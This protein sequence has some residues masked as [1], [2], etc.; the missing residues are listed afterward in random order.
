MGPAQGLGLGPQVWGLGAGAWGLGAWGLGPG[1]YLA[2]WGLGASGRLGSGAYWPALAWPGI[3]H[4]LALLCR[5]N[6]DVAHTG[7]RAAP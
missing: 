6:S 3:A 7:L 4:A 2:A 5:L 1:R